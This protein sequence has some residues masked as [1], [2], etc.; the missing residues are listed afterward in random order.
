MMSATGPFRLGFLGPKSG[1]FLFS[2]AFPFF[3]WPHGPHIEVPRLGVE[4]DLQLLDHSQSNVRS[5]LKLPLTPQLK[6]TLGP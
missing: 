6:A 4:L 2:P 3:L 1:S 5:K